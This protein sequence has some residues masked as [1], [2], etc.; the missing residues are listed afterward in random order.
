MNGYRSAR[1]VDPPPHA[2]SEEVKAEEE[3]RM[4][5]ESDTMNIQRKKA[6]IAFV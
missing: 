2:R 5:E 4:N 3:K 6:E 1:G